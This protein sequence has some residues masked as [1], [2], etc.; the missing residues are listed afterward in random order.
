MSQSEQDDEQYSPQKP[1]VNKKSDQAVS[2]P[3]DETKK[4][5]SN[6]KTDDKNQKEK[7]QHLDEPV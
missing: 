2:P 5:S 4:D 6:P 3:A 7:R 1:D